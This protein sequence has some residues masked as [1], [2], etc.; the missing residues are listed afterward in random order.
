[1]LSQLARGHLEYLA[2][3]A[4]QVLARLGQADPVHEG[5]ARLQADLVSGVT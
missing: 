3:R 2:S 5:I 4:G 1:M